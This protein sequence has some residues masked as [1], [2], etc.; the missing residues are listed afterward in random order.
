MSDQYLQL[1]SSTQQS[2]A[3]ST[4]LVPTDSATSLVNLP[5]HSS[6]ATGDSTQLRPHTGRHLHTLSNNSLTHPLPRTSTPTHEHGHTH[7]HAHTNL[8]TSHRKLEQTW[9]TPAPSYAAT[10]HAPASRAMDVTHSHTQ[11]ATTTGGVGG[12]SSSTFAHKHSTC[13]LLQTQAHTGTHTNT[14]T[15]THTQKHLHQPGS[16]LGPEGHAQDQARVTHSQ[17]LTHSQAR[18]HSPLPLRKNILAT[19]TTPALGSVG[20]LGL[21]GGS[22]SGTNSEAVGTSSNTAADLRARA[23]TPDGK[24]TLMSGAAEGNTGTQPQPHHGERTNSRPKSN[25]DEAHTSTDTSTQATLEGADM[26][27]IRS[28]S[29]SSSAPPPN[30]LPG[31]SGQAAGDDQCCNV[32]NVNNCLSVSGKH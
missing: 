7:T 22:G 29:G 3:P 4:P 27:S 12:S 23:V 21:G 30:S 32:R 28:R 17:I 10:A 15:S 8:L 6:A 18:A 2:S 13:G 11:L 19:M 31:A 26:N 5:T 25:Q 20:G 24:H 14:H 1:A 16:G 9:S